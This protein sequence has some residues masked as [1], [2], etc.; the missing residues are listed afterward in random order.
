MPPKFVTRIQP[1]ILVKSVKCPHR[2][3]Q[4]YEVANKLFCTNINASTINWTQLLKMHAAGNFEENC[5]SKYM[6]DQYQQHKR[7]VLSKYNSM[8]DYILAKYFDETL[9][10]LDKNTGKLSYNGKETGNVYNIQPNDFP[11]NFE[12]DIKH[13]LI[14]STYQLTDD[15]VEGICLN[16]ILPSKRTQ[17]IYWTNEVNLQ[18]VIHRHLFHVHVAYLNA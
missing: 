7:N 1:S 17:Y 18:S 12:K 10:S 8:G 11:Y 13:F 3:S 15:E 5:R 2:I 9:V 4:F 6:I 14:W 16:E